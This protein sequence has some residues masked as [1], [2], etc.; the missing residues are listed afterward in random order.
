VL[1]LL[2]IGWAL[3]TPYRWLAMLFDESRG[4]ARGQA[5]V[6]VILATPLMIALVVAL[7]EYV[8]ATHQLDRSRSPRAAR[9]PSNRLR[10]A[11]PDLR[12]TEGS[13]PQPRAQAP[14]TRGAL[15][16]RSTIYRSSLSPIAISAISGPTTRSVPLGRWTPSVS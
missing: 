16:W 10:I 3:I 15:V 7:G 13:D 6:A 1:S 8:A 2:A 12:L 11:Q 5:L 4:A 14:T 9:S